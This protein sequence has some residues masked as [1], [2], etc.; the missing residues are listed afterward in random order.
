MPPNSHFPA[1][2]VTFIDEILNG[3][4]Y[5]FCSESCKTKA[6]IQKGKEKWSIKLYA[7]FF[8]PNNF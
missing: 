6:C 8:T 1:D 5:F 2:L 7:D 4:A 3:K